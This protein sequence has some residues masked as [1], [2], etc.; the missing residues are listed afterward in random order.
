M[1][2]PSRALIEAGCAR[3]VI[4]NGPIDAAL[5]RSGESSALR[6]QQ[7]DG[8]NNILEG[9]GTKTHDNVV[10]MRRCSIKAYIICSD[11]ELSQ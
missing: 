10:R 2:G 9:I 6:H 11:V 5:V 3:L 4:T 7:S 1:P 8:S